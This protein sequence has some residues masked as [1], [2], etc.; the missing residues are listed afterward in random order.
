ML[1]ATLGTAEGFDALEIRTPEV[2][3]DPGLF[4]IKL[5]P[6]EEPR[7]ALIKMWGG[8]TLTTDDVRRGLAARNRVYNLEGTGSGVAFFSLWLA[9]TGICLMGVFPPTSFFDAMIAPL[10]ATAAA[11]IA[12]TPVWVRIRKI[13]R[14]FGYAFA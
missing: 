4:G 6:P 7:Y 2:G 13:K 14:Q 5:T 3:P 11:L 9:F 12:T 1:L 10:G 8:P